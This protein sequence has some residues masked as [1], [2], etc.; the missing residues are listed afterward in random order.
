MSIRNTRDSRLINNGV[1]LDGT[2]IR[3]NISVGTISSSVC[4]VDYTSSNIVSISSPSSNFTVNLINAPL[5]NNKVITVT[6][7]VTQG[8]TGRIPNAFQ[9]AGA[10]QTLRWVAG[11]TPTGTSSS[12]KIDVFAFSVV[13]QSNAWTVLGQ[14]S[15]NF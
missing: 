4:A 2:A 14:A 13:R 9:V 5:D 11:V 6:L 3:E 12:G 10:G 15:L 7:I 8:A 1:V